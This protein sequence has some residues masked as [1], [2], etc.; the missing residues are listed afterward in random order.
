MKLSASQAGKGGVTIKRLDRRGR[1]V[2]RSRV[3][4]VKLVAGRSST[5]AVKVHRRCLGPARVPL[6]VILNAM[7]ASDDRAGP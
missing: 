2:F 6:E 4:R 7:S 5:V 3:V 1:T